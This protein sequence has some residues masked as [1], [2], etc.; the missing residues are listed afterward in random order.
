[1]TPTTG[2]V[3]TKP[4]IDNM[5]QLWRRSLFMVS[6]MR[7]SEQYPDRYMFARSC[8]PTCKHG[9][10]LKRKFQR[11]SSQLILSI[12]PS[13]GFLTVTGERR[14]STNRENNQLVGWGRSTSV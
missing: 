7:V 8:G 13:G 14:I 9:R 1:M 5:G 10:G 4:N 2:R 6:L 3:S 12:E 11:M